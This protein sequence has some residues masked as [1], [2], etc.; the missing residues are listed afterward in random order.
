[1]FTIPPNQNLPLQM[2][3]LYIYI[4]ITKIFE[5]PTIFHVNTVFFLKKKHTKKKTFL[6]PKKK[7]KHFSKTRQ[8]HPIKT[9]RSSLFS[10]SL[11]S[12][13]PKP[14]TE[15]QSCQEVIPTQLLVNNFLYH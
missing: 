14:N 11:P 7:K 13:S 8:K 10:I 15:N 1:M 3:S 6:K 12:P 2:A 4:Y 9:N 5:T